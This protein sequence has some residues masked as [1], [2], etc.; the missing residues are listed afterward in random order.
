MSLLL[1]IDHIPR[2]L[3]GKRMGNPHC[4]QEIACST[5]TTFLTKIERE[6]R[7]RDGMRQATVDKRAE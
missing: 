1:D 3:T 4:R 6:I 5:T 2:I 7:R